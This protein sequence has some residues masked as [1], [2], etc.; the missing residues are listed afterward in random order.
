MVPHTLSSWQNKSPWKFTKPPPIPHREK[1][2]LRKTNATVYQKAFLS[3]TFLTQPSRGGLSRTQVLTQYVKNDWTQLSI[4]GKNWNS[5][6]IFKTTTTPCRRIPH[7]AKC[8]QMQYTPKIRLIRYLNDQMQ[9]PL[10]LRLQS[11]VKCNFRSC[12]GLRPPG[13]PIS[14]P[15]GLQ[16]D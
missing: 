4:V 9:N 14:R 7:A 11:R 15:A 16:T 1:V 10:E 12:W 13:T 8:P 5:R 2:P 3:K 6:N